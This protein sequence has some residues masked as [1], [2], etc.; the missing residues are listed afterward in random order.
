MM[1]EEEIIGAQ[2]YESFGEAAIRHGTRSGSR[3]LEAILG[4]PG[5]AQQASQQATKS[6][7]SN[8]IGMGEKITGNQFPTG[9]K[10][11]EKAA[12]FIS[13]KGAPSEEE[14]KNLSQ[15]ITG[16]FTKPQDAGEEF[17]DEIVSDFTSSIMGGPGKTV[18]AKG[19]KT[20]GQIVLANAAKYGAKE[21]GSGVL[22]QNVAKFGTLLTTSMFDPKGAKK[23]V[24]SLYK[25][26]DSAIPK[27]TIIPTSS[28]INSIESVEQQLTKGIGTPAKSALK[29]PLAD[30]KQKVAGG[31]AEV[32]ELLEIKKNLNEH[33][34]G[35]IAQNRLSGGKDSAIKKELNLFNELSNGVEKSL[36]EYGRHNPEFYK[37]HKMANEAHSGIQESKF[38]SNFVQKLASP[39]STKLRGAL[40]FTDEGL[41]AA[42]LLFSPTAAITGY[43]A[44]KGTAL[45]HRFMT[46][47]TLR[48]FYLGALEGAAKQHGSTVVRNMNKLG[49]AMDEELLNP[50]PID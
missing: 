26:R 23:Y 30:L 22:G 49:D 10:Y 1:P 25:Q 33:R 45:A 29:T 4:S 6:A 16:G 20:L 7:L 47:P 31:H 46:N 32:E 48:K 9:R 36:E 28:I 8:I 5:T 3:A 2:P 38:I 19:L 24:D 39:K 40:E 15:N 37:L 34:A 14:L 50:I 43:A 41:A 44:L 42:S 13:P 35:L 27:G 18:A 21:A 11:A 17:A 12:E